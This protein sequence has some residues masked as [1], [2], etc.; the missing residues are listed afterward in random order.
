MGCATMGDLE[1]Y[2]KCDAR[3]CSARSREIWTK[4]FDGVIW[5]LSFC[6]HHGSKHAA[7]LMSQGFATL[8]FAD[9]TPATR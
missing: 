6:A 3:D 9:S 7:A 8:E 2:I 5:P 1:V 4:A